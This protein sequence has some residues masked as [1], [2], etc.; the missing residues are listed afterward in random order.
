M[1]FPIASVLLFACVCV[2]QGGELMASA[3]RRSITPDLKNG[4]PVYMAGFGQ[5]RA[6]TGVH[7][8]LWVRCVAL[9]TGE[10]PLAVCA[11]DSI[12]LFWDDVRKIRAGVP[13]AT[14][15]VMSTH[16]HEGPDT[17]GLWGAKQGVS[18]IDE[19]YNALLVA[20][21][22]EAIKECLSTMRPAT[23][24]LAAVT[25]KDVAGYFD[26]SRPPVV[27]DPQI[28]A[29]AVND[30][31]RERIATL[32]NWSNHPEALGSKNTLITADWPAGLCA[33]LES[34]EGGLVVYVNG[35]V[36]GMQSP[37]GAKIIDP[38]TKQP[39]PPETFR[40]AEAVG[41]YVADH[42]HEALHDAERADVDAIIYREKLVEI[43][44]A[45][46]GFLM[47]AQAGLFKGR[48]AM[49]AGKSKAPVGYLRLSGQGRPK[50]EV[51][52][53]PGEM[54]PELS[55][56]G[57]VKDPAG[58]FPGAAVERPVKSMLTAP[59]KMLFGLANDEIGYIIPKVQW[60]E[61]PPYTF[62]S[63]KRWYGE[64]NSV[65]PEAAPIIAQA[66]EELVKTSGKP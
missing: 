10:K 46:Q 43:P 7:D 32:V 65:G 15:L 34:L 27:H 11:V 47:A 60:D 48:Q 3:A 12:G 50:L 40:F 62:G 45:N 36:G 44:V 1:R 31:R 21:A 52:L 4:R 63:T 35:A 56:G 29:L 8:D 23:I 58:D 57:V 20:R 25:P 26:D 64:V 37:L 24:S 51:A 19:E 2:A 28:L 33:R 30:M 42:V 17:M 55:V 6:A 13:Q 9:S 61:K 22:V 16:V 39:A 66:L 5:G 41:E 59:Y 14:V 18:G 54:Y 38:R 49:E 53:I